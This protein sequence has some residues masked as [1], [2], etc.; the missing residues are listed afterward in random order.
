MSTLPE[1]QQSRVFEPPREKPLDQAAWQA[2]IDK[3]A[4]Q[5]K[6]R[7][8]ARVKVIKWVF[9]VGL[10][11]LA[12]LWS[13]ATP[14]EVVIKFVVASGATV[15]MFQALRTRQY[16]FAAVFGAL[17]L[18]YNP[19]VP[20]FNFS[21]EWQRAF[22]AVSAAPFMASLAPPNGTPAYND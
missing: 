11:A 6:R 1:L 2:W 10:L 17:A 3:G 9:I 14:Y 8:M 12:V 4:A 20:V 13:R 19:L 21:G 22:V 15:M 18:I 16:A 7:S 5:D